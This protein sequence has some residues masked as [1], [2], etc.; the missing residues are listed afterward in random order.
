MQDLGGLFGEGGVDGAGVGCGA[1]R[2]GARGD[3]VLEE[4]FVDD[5][6]DGGDEGADVF[7]AGG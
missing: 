2:E 6:D 3:V 5:I 4:L 7:G 1:C